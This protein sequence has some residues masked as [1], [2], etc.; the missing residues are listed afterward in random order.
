MDR[1][2]ACHPPAIG[3]PQPPELAALR[4]T[5][6]AVF[7][8]AK[9]AARGGAGKEC[10]TCHAAI[11][12]TDDSELPR[13]TVNDCGAAACHDGKAAFATITACVRCHEHPP[14]DKFEVA[15]PELRFRHDGPHERVLA[16][17]ACASCHALDPRG[18][19]PRRAADRDP[20][21]RGDVAV[22]GHAACAGCHADD[23]GRRAPKICGAC[24]TATEPWRHLAADRGLP[25]TTEFGATLD[26]RNHGGACTTCHRLD[27]RTTQLRMPR[28]HAA[29]TGATCHALTGGPL[30][31][32]TACT[33]CHRLGRDAERVA[34]RAS[35]PW[36]VRAEFDHAHH[37]EPGCTSCHTDVATDSVVALPTPAKS[38]CTPCHD[39]RTAFSVTGTACARCHG[40]GAR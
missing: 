22:A 37:R 27:T 5:V 25:D 17:T 20:V 26:H 8:H 35:D 4:N 14:S 9:H 10:T 7:S 38:T 18:A 12:T 32:L 34:K 21:P 1:C 15:R 40:G 2:G 24:H 33:S 13:P 31:Q 29:C 19:G 16:T 11:R 6:S 28:G 23:F 36:S 39:G 3:K 30:P